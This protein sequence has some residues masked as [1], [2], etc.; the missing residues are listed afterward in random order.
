[1]KM[2]RQPIPQPPPTR[3]SHPIAN[4]V[5]ARAN[6]IGPF[7]LFGLLQ[8]GHCPTHGVAI[9][10]GSALVLSRARPRSQSPSPDTPTRLGPSYPPLRITAAKLGG[11]DS[12]FP[13]QFI[14]FDQSC[15]AARTIFHRLNLLI[16]KVGE[17]SGIFG[18]SAP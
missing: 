3:P 16:H 17:F 7:E 5:H 4:C 14:E 13:L 10:S 8:L 18:N 15:S 2:S 12:I 1:M 6:Q 9:K 11:V